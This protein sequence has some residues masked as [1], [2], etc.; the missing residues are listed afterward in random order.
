MRRHIFLDILNVKQ[1]VLA[2]LHANLKFDQVNGERRSVF[3]GGLAQPVVWALVF[4]N[5]HVGETTA[6]C[7]KFT[8]VKAR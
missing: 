4:T 6:E 2:A 8:E 5:T 3:E 1:Q 7:I